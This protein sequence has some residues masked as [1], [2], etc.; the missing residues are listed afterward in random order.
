MASERS[1]GTDFI[2]TAIGDDLASGRFGD[3]VA[4]RFP[5]E[6]NGHPHIGHVPIEA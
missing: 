1:T 4:T 5:P 2:R 3:R 6:P